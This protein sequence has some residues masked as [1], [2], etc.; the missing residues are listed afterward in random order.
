MSNSSQDRKPA[1]RTP[2]FKIALALLAGAGLAGLVI[3]GPLSAQDDGN[4][5]GAQGE[6]TATDNQTAD[7][8][9][10]ARTAD[11]AIENPR[12]VAI[13]GGEPITDADIALSAQD[14]ADTIANYPDNQKAG[15]LLSFL[16][17]QKLMAQAGVK[18]ELQNSE[19]FK[20]RMALLRDRTLR[21]LYFET[22][23]RDEVTE[24]DVREAYDTTVASI[25]EEEEVRARHI[26]VE[27]EEDAKAIAEE[28]DKG[29][30]FAELAREKSTGPS[31]ENGGDLGYFGKRDMVAE[32]ADAAFALEKGQV[33][34]P[35]KTE[36]G[37]H[38]IKLEDRRAKTPP[39]L[40]E[41]R[42][43]IVDNLLRARYF[44]LIEDLKAETEITILDENGAEISTDADDADADKAQDN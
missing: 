42:P 34:T 17:N 37:W 14:L 39:P 4:K 5:D 20:K 10:P 16:I 19:K 24:E 11:D 3:A 40:A 8:E 41:V 22:A 1:A 43:Q 15:V 27:S 9:K 7:A 32:F 44:K 31:S 35:V 2:A 36:F 26:L 30:D 12:T 6:Q 33:S 38:V 28:L 29:A 23:V 18:D 21:D 25:A 13:V